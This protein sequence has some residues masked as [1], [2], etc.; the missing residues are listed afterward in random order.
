MTH[1]IDTRTTDKNIFVGDTLFK[2]S[3]GRTDLPGGNHAELINSIQSKILTLDGKIVVYPGHGESTNIAFDA[4]DGTLYPNTLYDISCVIWNI[5]DMSNNK[6][7]G[8]RVGTRPKDFSSND[9]SQ[10]LPDTSANTIVLKIHNAQTSGTED[11]SGYIIDYNGNN[12]S[13]ASSGTINMSSSNFTYTDWSPNGVN[14]D[15]SLNDLSANTTYDLSVC[16]FNTF[17]DLSNSKI[18]LK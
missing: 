10:N 16:L 13:N 7:D 2:N 12:G 4:G 5:Y 11:I 3:I 18:G 9:I 1:V 15:I 6:S 17:N 14:N 8:G